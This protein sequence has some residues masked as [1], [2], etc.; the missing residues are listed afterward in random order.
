[1]SD[2]SRKQWVPVGQLSATPNGGQFSGK[3]STLMVVRPPGA[4]LTQARRPLSKPTAQLRPL[5]QETSHCCCG[6]A[7]YVA[8]SAH[9]LPPS[10]ELSAAT[11]ALDA[12]PPTSGA[13]DAPPGSQRSCTTRSAAGITGEIAAV[14]VLTP[15]PEYV[16]ESPRS[17]P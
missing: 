9:D 17:P 6:P 7:E 12:V 10:V 15:T 3:A 14:E 13:R 11:V 2:V 1:M 8:D 5:P 16:T 4:L